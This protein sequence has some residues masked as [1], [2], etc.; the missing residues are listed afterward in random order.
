[1][2]VTPSVK[3]NWITLISIDKNCVLTAKWL[4]NLKVFHFQLT[5]SKVKIFL[6]M[7]GSMLVI[8]KDKN[9]TSK[10][11]CPIRQKTFVCIYL[12]A[13]HDKKIIF[14]FPII[15]LSQKY[16]LPD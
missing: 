2:V 8:F 5:H 1:M 16:S 12:V 13:K 10:K 3:F 11:W 15:N 4:T 6:H 9:I 7:V 14:E